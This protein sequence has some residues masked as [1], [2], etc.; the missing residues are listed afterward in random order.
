MSIQNLE[1]RL[2]AAGRY[3]Q[4]LDV[5]PSSLSSAATCVEW[6][7]TLTT[8]RIGDAGATFT[9]YAESPTDAI[10]AALRSASAWVQAQKDIR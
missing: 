8:D 5:R 4:S 10:D 6:Q 3:I 2:D 1:K 7:A 9:T